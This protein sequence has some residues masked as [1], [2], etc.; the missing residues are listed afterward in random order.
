M[1][2][3]IQETKLVK[4]IL[5]TPIMT[6]PSPDTPRVDPPFIPPSVYNFTS[7]SSQWQFSASQHTVHL[8]T[9]L[10]ILHFFCGIGES[11]TNSPETRA[12]PRSFN[13]QAKKGMFSKWQDPNDL[14]LSSAFTL[15]FTLRFCYFMI[16]TLFTLTALCSHSY[17]SCCL[18]VEDM[19]KL[20][21][22]ECQ[23]VRQI[24]ADW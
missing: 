12:A 9:R 20:F 16:F 2:L 14:S 7:L 6:P 8:I 17:L 22:A 3:R 4:S 19:L 18:D 5:F 15:G 23:Y 21:P 11:P 24:S 10:S 13:A 1:H